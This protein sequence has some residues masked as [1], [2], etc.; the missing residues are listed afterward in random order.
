M[1]WINLA[2]PLSFSWC[3]PG[4][5][6]LV[7]SC[8]AQRV[9]GCR[10]LPFIT[11]WKNACPPSDLKEGGGQV[12]RPAH[13][14]MFMQAPAHDGATNH[15]ERTHDEVLSAQRR[16]LL[17]RRRTLLSRQAMGRIGL[18]SFAP[19]GRR[20]CVGGILLSLPMK[21]RSLVVSVRPS[22]GLHAAMASS[23]TGRSKSSKSPSPS[24]G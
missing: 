12:A 18:L 8:S 6:F 1:D 2:S 17:L 24:C 11:C 16:R 10:A 9:L 20:S 15:E 4:G 22:V 13:V 23:L 7:R 5:S 3:D 14:S 21:S 19:G